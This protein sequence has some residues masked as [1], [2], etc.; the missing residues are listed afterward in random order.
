MQ[1]DQPLKPANILAIVDINQGK[2]PLTRATP[3]AHALTP[4][5]VKQLVADG[6]VVVDARSAAEFGAGHIHG[7]I[8]VQLSSAEFEQRV[9]WVTADDA[10]LILVTDSAAD[11]QRCLFNMAFIGLDQAV[12]GYL[13]GGI[14]AWMAAGEPLQTV[15]QLDVHTLQHRLATNGLQLLDVRDEEE[16]DEGHVRQAHFM[17]YRYL[18]PQLTQ[19][20]QIGQL[21]LQPDQPLAVTCATGKRS[22]TAISLLSRYGYTRLYN[23]TGGMVAWKDAGFELVD[24]AGAVCAIG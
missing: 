9:G 4:A 12:A 3:V 23:V 7:A 17:P 2:R 16:W 5:R 19:P 1:D 24:A 13:D 22:S 21:S 18:V 15:P 8:N 14:E 6:H 10:R 11:A 20:A